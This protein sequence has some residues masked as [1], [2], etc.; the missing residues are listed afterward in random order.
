MVY[1][2]NSRE[3][4]RIA[5]RMNLAGICTD[6]IDVCRAERQQHAQSVVS[7]KIECV[8]GAYASKAERL[9]TTVAVKKLENRVKEEARAQA[10]AKSFGKTG[11]SVLRTAT[12]ADPRKLVTPHAA[13]RAIVQHS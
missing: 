12:R 9:A 10:V 8:T 5:L 13:F 11:V 4:M 6:Y 7:S 3:D 2:V 1:T